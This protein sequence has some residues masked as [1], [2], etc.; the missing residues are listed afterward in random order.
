MTDHTPDTLAATAD[1]APAAM[2]GIREHEL[3]LPFRRAAADGTEERGE[4]RVRLPACNIAGATMLGIAIAEHVAVTN[5]PESRAARW[6]PDIEGIT[7]VDVDDTPSAPELAAELDHWRRLFTAAVAKMPGVQI[8]AEEYQAA[9][10]TQ[11]ALV[12]AGDNTMMF[13]HVAAQ[14]QAMTAPSLGLLHPAAGDVVLPDPHGGY[15]DPDV[16][17][18]KTQNLPMFPDQAV[19]ILHDGRWM[20]MAGVNLK[21]D[22]TIDVTVRCDDAQFHTIPFTDLEQLVTARPAT[23]PGIGHDLPGAAVHDR[24]VLTGKGW[25][26][27]VLADYA[28]P[29]SNTYR[30]SL[31]LGDER[32]TTSYNAVDAVLLRDPPGTWWS[33]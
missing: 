27:V 33:W 9:D 15:P 16:R 4:L 10:P 3:H 26:D 5:S 11:L 8:T 12:P 7:A 6:L 32:W 31:R 28:G 24:Q 1:Q 23:S 13:I 22:L 18:V 14:Q 17:Q 29:T 25:A 20:L 2:T 30:T 19:D 21:A